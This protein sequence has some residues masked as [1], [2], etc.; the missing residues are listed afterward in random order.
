MSCPSKLAIIWFWHQFFLGWKSYSKIDTVSTPVD[1]AS[2]CFIYMNTKI[3]YT[4]LWIIA[5]RSVQSCSSLQSINLDRPLLPLKLPLTLFS[6]ICPCVNLV[7]TATKVASCVHSTW[8]LKP[9]LKWKKWNKCKSEWRSKR[10][11]QKGRQEG[12]W[13][14]FRQLI[15]FSRV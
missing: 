12:K 10:M 2:S 4:H 14:P 11:K 7:S 6:T 3:L 8:T 5:T 9:I 15:N 13:C 1:K